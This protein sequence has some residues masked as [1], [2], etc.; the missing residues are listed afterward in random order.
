VPYLPI[1]P[2]DLGRSYEAVIRVNSQSGKGG[3][4]WVLEQDQ[5]LKLPKRMQPHFS[6]H[7]QALADEVGRELHAGDIWDVFQNAYRLSGPQPFELR[8][9]DESKGADGSHQFVGQFGVD[10]GLRTILG[11]GNGT[12][13]SVVNA[14][15]GAFG[16]EL[17]VRDYTE[18]AIGS[19]SDARAAAFL[20]C[21]GP[22]GQ[23][24]W[25]VG[26]DSDI[27]TAS[28]RAVLSAANAIGK[29]N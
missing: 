12:I 14:I 4:A 6:R 11:T 5:G 22:D 15:N 3:F 8:S 28:V 29:R 24:V 2:A 17:E 23:A 10:G 21:T 1:D 20:E 27:A 18:H 26:I 9:F 16:V 19:G 7:V 25:G 13:S